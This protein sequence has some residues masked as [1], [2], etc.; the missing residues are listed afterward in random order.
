ML[1]VELARL[2]RLTQAIQYHALS[3]EPFV[4]KVFLGVFD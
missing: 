4:G 1:L 2:Q 3:L